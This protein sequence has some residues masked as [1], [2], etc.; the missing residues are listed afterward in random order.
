MVVTV[1]AIPL[2]QHDELIK[3]VLLNISVDV[4]YVNYV[5][6]FRN[7]EERIQWLNVHI[8]EQNSSKKSKFPSSNS[9]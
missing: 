4:N 8:V 3:Y 6:L 7:A 2:F 9:A 1:V 5:I